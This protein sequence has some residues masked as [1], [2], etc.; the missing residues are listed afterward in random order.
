MGKYI[1]RRL[2]QMIP[3]VLG[4]TFLIYAMVFALPGD[5]TAGKCGERECSEAYKAAFYEK[6][7][8]NDPLPIQYGKYMANVVQGDLGE[9]QYGNDVAGE[10]GDRYLVTG[11]LALMALLWEGVIGIAAGALAGIRKGGFMD[12]LVLVS[13]L[14]LI[15]IPVFVT[16]VVS[17]F[18][19]GVKWGVASVTV[20][21][22]ATVYELLLPSFVLGSLSMA[23]IARLTRTNLAE[24]LRADYVRTAKAKGL[25]P[26]RTVGLHALR[27]SL[28]PVVTFM[29]YDFGALLGG[30]IVTEGIFNIQGVGGYIFRGV[31][32]RDGV[33]VVGAVTVLVVA[34]LLVN[35]LVDLLYGLLD[36]RI[37]HD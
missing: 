6:Y 28:I 10:L 30:A 22:D 36:P 20:S 29:G 2:L 17:Q 16:G 34:Y 35:L 33:A 12:S 24:N 27:N 21:A 4:A 37:S 15:S 7:N 11:K 23:Y 25:T 26:Q 18:F 14:F 19:L 1:V 31:N 5:P 8:L 13:T 32:N 3:V 9:N